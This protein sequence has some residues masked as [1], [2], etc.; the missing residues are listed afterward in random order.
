MKTL[1]TIDCDKV[2]FAM[3]IDPCRNFMWQQFALWHF[4]GPM[5]NQRTYGARVGRH[6]A[7]HRCGV[8]PFAP[9]SA[10][11]CPYLFAS[12][13]GIDHA[14]HTSTCKSYILYRKSSKTPL[15]KV[16]S[17]LITVNHTQSNIFGTPSPLP[18][19]S[20]TKNQQTIRLYSFANLVHVKKVRDFDE[21]K[22]QKLRPLFTNQCIYFKRPRT[23]SI[24]TVLANLAIIVIH[25]NFTYD[26]FFSGYARRSS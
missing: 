15:I 21:K 25:E 7:R 17:H 24:L 16:H 14:R 1:L 8:R 6:A 19:F 4:H 3:W 12:F 20:H 13:G 26:H 5:L 18:L 23:N 11:R 22:P 9:D 10:A 2:N